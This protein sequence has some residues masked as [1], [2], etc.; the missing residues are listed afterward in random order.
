MNINYRNQKE[1]HRE[2]GDDCVLPTIKRIINN[3]IS[4][5]YKHRY[6]I[7]DTEAEILQ[8]FFGSRIVMQD[9]SEDVRLKTSSHPILAILND[10][11]NDNS[12]IAASNY[13]SKGFKV[14]TIGDSTRPKI[15]NSL[16]NCLLLD[17]AREAY[18]ITNTQLAAGGDRAKM[19]LKAA[20]TKSN[21]ASLCIKGAQKCNF[22]A[23]VCFS[24]HSMYDV[25]PDELVD[26]F[27]KHNLSQ[28]VVYMYLPLVLLGEQ[29]RHVDEI[30]HHVRQAG[31]NYVFSMMDNSIPYLHNAKNWRTWAKFTSIT[32]GNHRIIREN[33]HRLGPLY[34][35]NLTKIAA[36]TGDIYMS[37][38]LDRIADKFYLVPSLLNAAHDRF[39]TQQ[40]KLKHHLVPQ[41]VVNQLMTYSVR[42]AD[43]S[44]KYVEFAA[45][46]S[47]LL[48]E[49]RIGSVVYADRWNCSP[50][51]YHDIT[52]S[53]FI[54]GATQRSERTQTISQA[55]KHLKAWQNAPGLFM[56]I[57]QF[58]C[59]ILN[60]F[61]D[62]YKVEENKRDYLWQYQIQEINCSDHT[63]DIKVEKN[64]TNIEYIMDDTPIEDDDFCTSCWGRCTCDD[65]IFDKIDFVQENT[66]E[67][68]EIGGGTPKVPEVE[69]KEAPQNDEKQIPS[70]KPITE[71]N[72]EQPE[73]KSTLT[74]I[75]EKPKSTMTKDETNNV[76]NFSFNED[77]DDGDFKAIL[78]SNAIRIT[79]GKDN[80]HTESDG[81]T[82]NAD[83]TIN[84]ARRIVK[85]I[86][87]S[88]RAG[89]CVMAAIWNTFPLE[90]KPQQRE[91]IRLVYNGLM[92]PA[93]INRFDYT[94]EDVRKYIYDGQYENAS[95]DLVIEVICAYYDLNVVINNLENNQ[96]ILIGSGKTK[97]NIYFARRHYSHVPNGGSK[98]KFPY[99]CRWIKRRMRDLKPKS[100]CEMSCAP[101]YLATLIAQDPDYQA[102]TKTFYHYSPG[103]QMAKDCINNIVGMNGKIVPYHNIGELNDKMLDTHDLII[104]DAARP[105]NSEA[106]IDDMLKVIKR[107]V[108]IGSSVVIKTFG[109]PIEV[110]KFMLLFKNAA[111]TNSADMDGEM[112]YIMTDYTGKP[113]D[114]QTIFDVY[115]AYK[116]EETFHSVHFDNKKAIKYAEHFFKKIAS[117][118]L[119]I[120]LNALRDCKTKEFTISAITGYAGTGKTH[121]A[122]QKHP[123]SMFIA[124]TRKLAMKHNNSGVTSYTPHLAIQPAIDANH[125]VIDEITQINVE[126]LMCIHALNPL[127]KIIVL[128]DIY[129]TPAID[130]DSK[131]FMS[132]RELGLKNNLWDSH[133]IP[134]DIVE[135]LNKKFG[136]TIRTTSKIINSM[137]TTTANLVE[138]AKLELQYICFNDATAKKLISD[139]HNA[140]TIT[141]FQGGRD[142]TIVFYIDSNSVTSQL[143]NRTEWVVTAM[144]RHKDQLVFYGDSKYITQ[145]L[146]I[147]GLPCRNLEEISQ[148][149]HTTDTY[150]RSME[151]NKITDQ[152]Q[153]KQLDEVV[154]E[155]VCEASVAVEIVS[156]AM[157]AIN[158]ASKTTAFLQPVELPELESG[159]I[160][161]PVVAVLHTERSF[162]GYKYLPN[163][164][165]VRNQVSND[166][167]ETIRTLIK[168]YS[169]K[170][171]K[172]NSVRD[173][174]NANAMLR[175]LARGLYDNDLTSVN[176]LNRDLKVTN[177]ELRFH[178]K[179]YLISA[180]KK[181]SNNSAFMKEL[182][183]EFDQFDETIMFVNKKQCKFD[184][185]IGFD[186]KDKVGQGVASMSKR[187]N[188]MMCAYSRALLAKIDEITRKQKSNVILATFDS[189]EKL[190]ENYTATIQTVSKGGKWFCADVSEWD[191]MFQPFMA[192]L[193]HKLCE[194]MGMP[195]S[196][197]NWFLEYRSKWTMNYA[198]KNGR[199]KLQGEGKQ[200][201]GNPFTICENTLCNFAMIN[202]LFT[203]TNPRMKMLKGDDSA[204]LCDD[205]KPTVE[206]TIMLNETKHN[207]KKHFCV[208]GE[209]AGFI[210][211]EVGMLPDLMRRVCKFLGRNYK[212]EEHFKEAVKSAKS[213]TVVVKSEYALNV[214][215]VAYTSVY[216]ELNVTATQA[217]LLFNFLK[218]ADRIKFT[219][220]T[221]VKE[222]VASN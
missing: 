21:D 151:S 184:A 89:H 172:T 141:T 128:G 44:Y 15:K 71:E 54:I 84:I 148:V 199:A 29:Y 43:E 125:I 147:N 179:E 108:K 82:I 102:S 137:C 176:E 7:T 107:K 47:G 119:P 143:I 127:A 28:M 65:Y 111:R 16:H 187:I 32:Y 41:H 134:Q 88:F 135:V 27:E 180:Q 22:Q 49:I 117:D 158:E 204:V 160:K 8:T 168:R 12:S 94:A 126:Y 51:D 99:I 103:L 150:I 192:K 129:Q 87:A 110:W 138:L 212:D 198:S 34:I 161:I 101:G 3:Q 144:T 39:A 4:N 112:Y 31:H 25:T 153:V 201:S 105:C 83:Q 196:L 118:K 18:R 200:F 221:P 5:A 38:P 165:L 218:N 194:M 219:H 185:D 173:T 164:P 104:C 45:V 121:T 63:M 171:P 37:L 100:I 166:S 120:V 56:D 85:D 197:N 208:I 174:G 62:D 222:N 86:P 1:H 182:N 76:V 115:D 97:V 2:I 9:D 217:R 183:A 139:K 149:H 206:G 132:F 40:S 130:Y 67:D 152:I 123:D 81:L 203:F 64:S 79:K 136:H 146:A 73:V 113:L 106:L 60:S 140:S 10:Y 11:C 205:Y 220:L 72:T 58:I 14:M 75:D 163:V 209:F 142:S 6:H 17:N 214:G 169:K 210:L 162:T 74:A 191:S 78:S 20:S 215:C 195:E 57:R 30:A 131:K 90:K 124:P 159:S 91:M 157:V 93:N 70:I 98:E 190:A 178:A 167:K 186:T 53:I 202:Y 80:Y 24:V 66:K 36:F 96:Q 61:D 55:F 216:P 77:Y 35:I 193:T 50:D 177:E 46:A 92:D 33:T 189:D 156:N 26:I 59:K 116:R 109:N 213:S 122:V 48:R 13:V 175:A 211:T 181:V 188:F 23:D 19:L 145:Y 52:I 42:Q 95:M 155:D 154:A 69:P 133:T 68:D 170:M 114:D 207:I